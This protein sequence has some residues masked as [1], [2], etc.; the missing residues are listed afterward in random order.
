MKS[1]SDESVG[2]DVIFDNEL[3]CMEVDDIDQ[4]EDFVSFELGK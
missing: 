2:D 3:K 4:K 1:G